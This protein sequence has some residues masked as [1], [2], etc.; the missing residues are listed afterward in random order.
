[1]LRFINNSTSA[2]AT[3]TRPISRVT[4]VDPVTNEMVS[5][6]FT[7]FEFSELVAFLVAAKKATY[8]TGSVPS[9]G[10]RPGTNS[11][12]YGQGQWLYID[13]YFGAGM[14]VGTEVVYFNGK[15]VWAMSY[16][17]FECSS[18][19]EVNQ[20]AVRCLCAALSR[21]DES[22]VPVRGVK[23]HLGGYLYRDKTKGSL[24][25]FNGREVIERIDDLKEVFYCNYS[26]GLIVT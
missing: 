16:S 9:E 8:A 15:P 7:E 12:K 13:E 17:G 5:H 3:A 21:V 24:I 1:M 19:P 2:T 22:D 23:T 11:F 18:D 25:K 4:A 26:G 20:G 6:Q 14:F 10:A